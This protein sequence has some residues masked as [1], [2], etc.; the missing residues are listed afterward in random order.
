MEMVCIEQPVLLLLVLVAVVS[1][2]SHE[3]ESYTCEVLT[4]IE[5]CANIYPNASFPNFRSHATQQEA[6]TEL[7]DFI[8]L[9][10]TE[11]S[12]ALVHM[13]CA[14]YAPFCDLSFGTNTRSKPCRHL[15][16]YVRE[17]CEDHFHVLQ[18]EDASSLPH[19]E[20]NQY[21]SWEVDRTCFGPREEELPS[22]SIPMNTPNPG[23]TID[24]TTVSAQSPSTASISVE[25]TVTNVLYTTADPFT[26]GSSSVNIDNA[27][28]IAVL[29]ALLFCVLWQ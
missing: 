3:G 14:V 12:N 6:N 11:C 1:A 10:E 29:M 13:L 26:S 22:V 18:V 19:F 5:I 15:C 28:I 16:Q 23:E 20:C 9:I 17:G 27:I 7:N 25:P 21:P 2:F 8:P 24:P 4:E